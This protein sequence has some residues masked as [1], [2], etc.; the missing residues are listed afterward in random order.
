MPLLKALE[1][2][3]VRLSRKNKFA[4]AKD[5]RPLTKEEKKI[6]D[7]AFIWNDETVKQAITKCKT[8]KEF[9]ENYQ[10]AYDYALKHGIWAELSKSLKRVTEHGKYTKEYVSK[11]AKE[12]LTRNEFK[13]K[14]KGAWA[15]AQRNGWLI[16][17][18]SHMPT[19]MQKPWLK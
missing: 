8:V 15:A 11:V 17:V 2:E 1:S 7:T 6:L 14:Y 10:S 18:C 9:R 5:P 4:F 13:Q 12:C 3:L 19:H 16:E